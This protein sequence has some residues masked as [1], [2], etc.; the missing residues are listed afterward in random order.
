MDVTLKLVSGQ[1]GAVTQEFVISPKGAILGRGR[2]ADIAVHDPAT[3][4]RHCEIKSEHGQWVIASLH[5]DS[6]TFVN[7]QKITTSPL[8]PGDVIRIGTATFTVARSELQVAGAA[9]ASGAPGGFITGFMDR[10]TSLAGLEAIK[11]FSVADMFS[12]IFKK[13]TENETEN[14]LSVGTDSTTP[15][16]KTLDLGWPKPWLFFKTLA[17]LAVVYLGFAM[18]FHLFNNANLLPGLIIMGSVAAP[19]SLMVFFYEVNVAR[20]ISFYQVARLLIL[21][22]IV[23]LFLTLLGYKI[24][25]MDEWLGPVGVAILEESGKAATLLLVVNKLRFRWTLNGLLFGAIV[26]AGFAIFESAGYAENFGQAGFKSMLDVIDVR[27]VLTVFG[28]HVL[29]TAIVGAALWRVR[30]AD[31]FNLGMLKD[32]RFLRAF[33]FAVAMHAAWD[34]PKIPEGFW[35]KYIVLGLIAWA[36]V[37]GYIQSGLQQLREAAKGA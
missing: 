36:L 23:S 1:G 10:V 27:G 7:E 4:A 25:E 37:L 31:R 15:D 17:L 2:G 19:L 14:Y 34:S 12:E 32:G 8:K 21:G 6:D 30:G 28:G 26:G 20:N 29:W 13:R 22:S 33:A 3:A 9:G 18:S 11:G 35:I 24:T 16:L 5:A